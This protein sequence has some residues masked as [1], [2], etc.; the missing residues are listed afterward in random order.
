M[1]F[2]ADKLHFPST[3]DISASVFARISA[4]QAGWKNLNMVALRLDAGKT[5]GITVGDYE[6]AAVILGGVCDIHT[7]HGDFLDIGRRPDVFTGMPYAVY[8]PRNTEFE[9]EALSDDFAMASSWVPTDKDFPLQLIRPKDVKVDIVGGGSATHQVNTIIGTDFNCHH[10]TVREIYTPGGNW[11]HFPPHKHDTHSSSN[12]NITEAALE[13]IFFYKFDRPNG[14]AVQRIYTDDNSIDATIT[15]KHNDIVIVPKGY[16]TMASAHGFTSYTLNITAGSA[17]SL[18]HTQ[19]PRYEWVSERW[20]NKDT[21]LPIVDH[22]MEPYQSP[23]SDS[24]S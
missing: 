10:L 6:Y 16:H 20:V 11:S 19:D 24:S 8:M 23:E 5:F 4:E 9:I 17:H 18:A 13:E 2:T 7:N 14:F 3:V 12:G 21:R 1:D 15:A 22:G